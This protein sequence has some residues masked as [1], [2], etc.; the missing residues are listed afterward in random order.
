MSWKPFIL[1]ATLGTLPLSV[2]AAE[3][4]FF[5]DVYPFLKSNCISCHNKTTTKADLN[6][7]TPED[8]IRGGESGPSI[9]PG[10]SA[11]SLIV[12]ASL[13]KEDMEMPPPNNKSG[14]SNLTASEI[15]MLKAWIDQGAKSSVL[16][17][18]EVAWQPL[19][20]GVHPIYSLAVTSD[21][22]YAACGRS[23]E[24]AIYDLA[25]RCLVAQPAEA[26]A[27][28][29]TAHRALV[30]SLAFSPDGQRLASGSFREVKIWKKVQEP[31]RNRAADAAWGGV[32]SA[33]SLDESQM[34]LADKT[35]ALSL[36]EAASG[37]ILRKIPAAAPSGIR[38]LSL[39]PNKAYAALCGNDGTL[40]VWSL[41]D[42]KKLSSTALAPNSLHAMTWTRDSKQIIT[43]S[44]DKVIRVWDMP[45]AG[46]DWKSAKELQGSGRSV[47]QLACA[48]QADVLASASEDNQ[49]RIWSL[50]DGK[51]LREWNGVGALQLALS[52]DG[53]QLVSSGADGVLR[54]W[55]VQ[56][57]KQVVELRGSVALSQRTAALEWSTAREV[58]EQAFQKTVVTRIEA[59]NKAL[60]ELLKKANE[61][62]I[63]MT[64]ALPEKQKL[65]QPATE[66]KSAAQKIADTA[67]AEVGKAPDAQRK[68]VLEKAARDAQE[69]VLTATTAETSAL[70]AVAAVESN[71]KD[72]KDDVQRITESKS[73]NAN[74]LAVANAAIASSKANQT[75][76]TSE[77]ASLKQSASKGQGTPMTVSFSADA[78]YVAA[79]DSTGSL[80]IWAVASGLPVEQI[81]ASSS[82][83]GNVIASREGPFIAATAEGAVVTSASTPRWVLERTLG[84]GKSRKLFVDRVNAVR[85]SPDGKTLATGSGEPSRSGDV[86]LF[87]VATGKQL[88]HWKERHQDAVLSL[89]FSPDGKQ[90]ASGAADKLACV[91]DLTTGKIRYTFEGHTHHVMG[92]SYRAD[93]RVLAT[94][95]ADGAV[96][97]WDMLMGERKKKIEG[98]TKEVTSVQFIGASNQLVTSA[99]DNLV[100]IIND[101]GGQVR[102][103]PKLPDFMQAAASTPSGTTVIGGGEDSILRVWDGTTGKEIIGFSSPK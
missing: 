92:I 68:Q 34:I 13:H 17:E 94:A 33:L 67:T 2:Q 93:G 69:K 83:M 53:K 9:V 36:L 99:G 75:K 51:L 101:D 58:L 27:K 71:I 32:L 88:Q 24:I 72:A 43:G 7:E 12:L 19:A 11:E 54:V 30:Q 78:R 91:T 35:G 48:A 42:G 73:K 46:A 96:I 4:D 52:E 100:R 77:L 38:K 28:S 79:L 31:V 98:W 82:G 25:S 103:M 29:A 55:E 84:S 40:A 47:K 63:T 16:E 76:A 49:I 39:S 80:R 81:Q 86:A 97:A 10:K 3:L 57:G 65:V 14:A 6:M 85:F 60:E 21:G 66:A 70:A 22:R 37:K 50:T 95:G 18:Q 56:T 62:I 89:D 102:A 8:M 23:N 15:A 59:Q 90:L 74:E 1:L 5:R 44:E 26:S 87:E 64:K 61:A 20:A 45:V 41:A